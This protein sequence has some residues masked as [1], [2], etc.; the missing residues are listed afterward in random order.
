MK[1]LFNLPVLFLGVGLVLL[2]VTFVKLPGLLN[3]QS[4][5]TSRDLY[6][7]AREYQKS[8]DYRQAFHTYAKI[9]SGYPAYDVVLFYEAKCAAELQDEKTVIL[10]FKKLLSESKESPLAAQA[11]YNLGQAYIRILNYQEAANQFIETIKKY[12]ETNF[13]IGSYYYLGQIYKDTDK[14]QA[15][16]YWLKY[17]EEAPSGRFSQNCVIGLKSLSKKS[18]SNFN[19]PVSQNKNIATALFMAE[20]YTQAISYLKQVPL[21]YSWYYLGKS[22]KELGNRN[23]ALYFYKEGMRKSSSDCEKRENFQQAMIDYVSLSSK[24]S[25][26]SWDEILG[27]SGTARDFALYQRAGIMPKNKALKYYW[28]IISKYPDGSFAS[29]ALWNLFQDAY[30]NKKDNYEFAIKLGEKH[31]AKYE[32]TKAASAILFWMGKI[33]EKKGDDSKALHFYK[34]TLSKYPDSYYAFRSEGRITAIKTGT[35]PGWKTNLYNKIPENQTQI[36]F[37]YSSGEITKKYGAG[38][39]ELINIGDYETIL[40]FLKNDPF[41][42]SWICFQNGIIMKSI[43]IARNEMEKLSEKPAIN[44][45]KWKLIYPVYYPENI[46]QNA[47]LNELDP[48]IVLSLMKEE[49]YF[50]PFAL[51]SSNARGLM[52]LLPGTAKDI[53]RW[54]NL[55]SYS[56]IELF[57]PEINIRLGTAY[58]NHTRNSLIGNMLYAVAAYNGGPG[59]VSKWLTY[60]PANDL[61]EFIENIPYSQTR[62]YVKKVYRSYWNYKRIYDLK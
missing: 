54:K 62:D 20:K 56:S 39:V 1:K 12:P 60:I 53:S 7:I 14:N 33:Y 47:A 2:A 55:G 34:K 41:F 30:V 18:S 52:Q 29:E 58:L 24:S 51:S 44:D 61:D 50:N 46:N 15:A 17:L 57:D 32:N 31:M 8:G 27:F 13:A 10:K 26:K 43:V 28:E 9:S 37:P 42:E 6:K 38:I 49:S 45:S 21:K 3:F 25:D 22:Y 5:E 4:T 35:D 11:S 19:A 23:M 36:G 40:S 16:Q 59:A 48:I